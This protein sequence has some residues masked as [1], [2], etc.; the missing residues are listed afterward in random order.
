MFD[1]LAAAFSSNEFIP[2]GHCF[3]WQPRVLWLHVLSDVGIGLS[4]YSIPVSLVYVAR[5]RPDLPFR[6]LFALF[7]LFIVLCG[8]THFFNIWVLWNPDYV[9]EG[10]V[11]AMTALASAFTAVVV[12]KIMPMALTMP[13]PAQLQ[14]MNTQ[15]KETN[16]RVE[17][18][19]AKRTAEL[20]DTESKLRQAQKMEAIGSLTG[21]MAHD[22]N[23]L[24]SVVIGNLDAVVERV[25]GA[26]RQLSQQALD[27]ALR[28]ADLTRRLLA[29]ARRQPL[30]PQ[31][32]DVNKLVDGI[33]KLLSRTLG[34]NIQITFN[35][36][37]DAWLVVADAVQL[38]ASLTN[39]ATNARDAMPNGGRLTITTGNRVLDEQYARQHPEV[40]AGD[41]VMIEV[42]DTGTG[43]TPDVAARIFE[44]FFTTKE[45]GKGSGL[46]L[47]MVYGYAKQSGGHVNVYSEVGIGTTFR[48]YLP[49]A[50]GEAVA[51]TQSA[52]PAPAKQGH[53]TV[54]V[55][56]DNDAVR[57]V[58]VRQ[59]GELGYH[60]L[61][62]VDAAAALEILTAGTR[63]DLLFT[64][65]V[66]PGKLN[67]L[68]LARVAMGRWPSL[69]IVLT[70]GFPETKVDGFA[71]PMTSGLRLLS[72]PYRKDEL[73]RV[74]RSALE[75]S[76]EAS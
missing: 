32:V 50:L 44:P 29:F 55:V 16:L 4:Y 71:E 8:S 12:W 47:S 18:E 24:L 57:R 28:G 73:A 35:P 63:V 60:V 2:H 33:T 41:Y 17:R 68:D 30:Q 6:Y 31:H 65:I 26:A 46:G 58:V 56:E 27:A 61:E 1:Q 23:N 51:P 64:D 34:E 45:I 49:R 76:A 15:L 21:G 67:G 20:H 70:S 36:A 37:S 74:L 43:M 40:V 38:E 75:G 53:E 10:I 11:K 66:M 69:K 48:L 59:L 22:F 3:L 62:S 52:E 13:S 7:S 19:V 5:K 54:L 9:P 72:K 25:D 14:E 42:S 39:L